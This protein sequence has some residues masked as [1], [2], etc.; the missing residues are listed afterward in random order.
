MVEPK[1]SRFSGIG[2]RLKEPT[3]EKN[4]Y[5]ADDFYDRGSEWAQARDIL[6]EGCAIPPSL[7]QFEHS[8]ERTRARARTPITVQQH[9]RMLSDHYLRIR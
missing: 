1:A 4:Y 7:E 2:S 3:L 9:A 5:S 8:L 6:E